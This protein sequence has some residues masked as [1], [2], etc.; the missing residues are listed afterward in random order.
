MKI[1]VDTGA[2]AADEAGIARYIGCTLGAMQ[3]RAT[4]EDRWFL[5]GRGQAVHSLGSTM[6]CAKVYDDRLPRHA[7]RLASLATSLPIWTLRDKPDVF[8]GPAHRL[9]LWL[10][11]NTARVVTIHD[12]CWLK[13]PQTMRTTSRRLDA[14][15]MPRAL[16]QADRI[17]A[18]SQATANDLAQTF[19]WAASRVVVVNEGASLLPAPQ[20]RSALASLG[21]SAPY[22]LFVGTLEPRKNLP[23]LLEAFAAWR[24]AAH[25]VP[26]LVIAGGRGWGSETLEDRCNSLGLRDHVR[27][28]GRVDDQQLA[29][30]YAHA[31]FLAMPSLYEGFG[32]PLVEAMAMGTPVLTS[33]VAAMPEVAG[34]AGLLVDPLST[35]SICT[36]LRHLAE[37]TSVRDGLAL[38]ARQQA[39]RYSWIRCAQETLTVLREAAARRS[40]G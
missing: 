26:K 30:L 4:N 31:M 34:S 1:A 33:N 22:I 6:A 5:Y 37:D 8:W 9:P 2:Y 19:T 27:W 35:Q 20:E 25:D 36:G 39:E 10:P 3:A 29:T 13:A 28:V 15:L 18:V 23:R 17:I 38:H 16:R 12:L 21:I 40:C 32:L 11:R 24:H 14:T 7:G